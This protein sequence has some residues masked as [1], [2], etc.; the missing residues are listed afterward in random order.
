[1]SPAATSEKEEGLAG[2]TCPPGRVPRA[3]SGGLS[4]P[5]T[6]YVFALRRPIVMV[7]R[8]SAGASGSWM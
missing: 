6:P 3:P 4:S 1:M 8:E 5:C 2:I 7:R